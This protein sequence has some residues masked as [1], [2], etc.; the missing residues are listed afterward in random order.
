MDV[1]KNAEAMLKKGATPQEIKDKLNTSEVVNVMASE[2]TLEIGSTQLPK[3]IKQEVGVS[4]ISQQGEYYFV[5]KVIKIIPESDKTFDECKGKII[6]DYQQY[7]E[8]NW[9][10]ELKKEFT[11]K[12]NQD[13]FERIKN[14]IKNN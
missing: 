7:L 13:T 4:E 11:I 6:N 2:N 8:Q 14:K 12:V 3:D 5:T 10:N 9:V 1:I